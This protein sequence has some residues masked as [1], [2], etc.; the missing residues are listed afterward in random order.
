MATSTSGADKSPTDAAKSAA[1]ALER[2]TSLNAMQRQAQP[3]TNPPPPPSDPEPDLRTWRERLATPAQWALVWRYGVACAAAAAVARYY[4]TAYTHQ[5]QIAAGATELAALDAALT[6]QDEA[7]VQAVLS[8]LRSGGWS[9]D[10]VQEAERVLRGVAAQ[11]QDVERVGDAQ[12]DSVPPPVAGA[13][14]G[15]ATTRL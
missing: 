8:E 11:L 7:R 3:P 15:G 9:V 14:P 1:A 2:L 13:Q 12:F 4:Y 5:Q 10:E 6:A